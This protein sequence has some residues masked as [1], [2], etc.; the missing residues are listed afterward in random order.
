MK[1]NPTSAVF[2]KS[3]AICFSVLYIVYQLSFI[4]IVVAAVI[5]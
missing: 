3:F 2:G 4:I 5:Y 1:K